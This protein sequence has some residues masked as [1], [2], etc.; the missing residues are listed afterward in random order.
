[1]YTTI[2][3]WGNSHALRIP[4]AI[5][6]KVSLQENDKVEIIV[7]QDAILIRK[8]KPKYKNLDELFAN[9]QGN[10]HCEEVDTGSPVGNEV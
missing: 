3:K 6:E 4:K 8:A 5:L 7:D 10:Y 9:Y 2:Q 1:M